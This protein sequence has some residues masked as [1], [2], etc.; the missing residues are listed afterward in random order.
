MKWPFKRRTE[1]RAS[2]TDAVATAIA[3][4]AA[5]A[6]SASPLQTAA[7]EACA[8]LIGRAFAS[9]TVV[10]SS[11]VQGALDPA[12]LCL[13]GRSLIRRGEIVLAIDTGN[14]GLSLIPASEV[15]IKGDH[16]PSSW[17]YKLTLPGP[18]RSVTRRVQ[19]DEVVHLRYSVEPGKPWLGVGP[20]QVAA[21]AG[22]L[23]AETVKALADEAAGPVEPARRSR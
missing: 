7:L 10:S 8:G 2:F 19:A 23:S 3:N 11:M 21:L 15:E 12:T 4:E 14:G 1:H 22:R 5:G 6:K 18:S 16:T 20:L 17:R 13:I 9:A